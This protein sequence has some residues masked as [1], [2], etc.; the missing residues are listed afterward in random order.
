MFD[1]YAGNYRSCVV[2]MNSLLYYDLMF[3]IR[4]L[5]DKY[6]LKKAK[7]IIS[8]VNNLIGDS[9]VKYSEIEIKIVNLCFEKGLIDKYFLEKANSMRN[10]RNH[11]AHIGFED[12]DVFVPKKAEVLMYIE[13][14]LVVENQRC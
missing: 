3:K 1:Y 4:E 14:N 6:E 11:C 2:S 13:V 8:K 10:I 12:N 9:G 5:S 7:E